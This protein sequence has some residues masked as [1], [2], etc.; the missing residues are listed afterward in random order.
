MLT[1]F[2]NIDVVD[3]TGSAP[4][5]NTTVVVEDR[6]IRSVDGS[7]WNGTA[8]LEID[9]RG[10]TLLPGLMD[11][12]IHLNIPAS[13]YE[14]DK[15]DMKLSNKTSALGAL[16]S[17][18]N[19]RDLIAKGVTT[20]RDVGAHGHGI[21]ALKQLIDQ[22]RTVG[23][24][25]YSCGRGINMTGGHGP[26]LCVAADGPDEVRHQTRK[27]M[28]AGAEIIKFM[29]SGA[30]AEAWESPYDVHLTEAEM[31]AGVQEAHA[32]GAT[33]AAHAVNPQSIV[34]SVNAGIDS[35][36]HGVLA[37][38]ASLQLMLEREV[39]LVPTIW[40]FQ[41]L[42]AQG[43]VIGMEK[44]FMKEIASRMDTH[45]EVVSRAHKMGIH[46]AVGTDS[47]LPVNAAASVIWE[48]QWLIHCGLTNLEAIRAA[49]LNGAQLLEI[50]DKVGTIAPDMLADILV[51]DGDPSVDIK[52]LH[53]VDVVMRSGSVLVKQGE[54][55]INNGR[56][57]SDPNNPPDGP[58]PPE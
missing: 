36:E 35:I 34:N 33:T 55:V 51:V 23:P 32:R 44:W 58:Y 21:F 46:L 52:Q 13:P 45:L 15:Y 49:T 26:R 7:G 1:V 6:K 9:G 30:A 19:A 54:I 18:D 28:M 14:A 29:A 11:M 42:A 50:D 2:R 27:Q 10:K 20:V 5:R 22:G 41:M 16:Y 4:R 24:R 8:D 37:D 38:E 40:T 3:G 17:I 25:I 43:S 12:H 57:I 39:H 48:M 56:M 47:A 31:A 53:N